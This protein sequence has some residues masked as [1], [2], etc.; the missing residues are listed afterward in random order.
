LDFLMG[1]RGPKPKP[2]EVRKKEGTYKPSEHGEVVV[3]GGRPDSLPAPAH[4]TEHEV[5]LWDEVVP[6]LLKVGL[7]DAVDAFAIEALVLSVSRWREAEELLKAEGMFVSSPNGYRIAHPAIAV[8]QKAQAEYRSWCARFG[9]TP[10]DRIGL[11]M[12]A[13]RSRS[14]SQDLAERIG[15]SPRVRAKVAAS[16]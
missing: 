8:A 6:P 5:A 14:L 2:A 4:L 1:A 15:P 12:A 9:L 13:V 10:S 11:G 16:E 3:I 7:L